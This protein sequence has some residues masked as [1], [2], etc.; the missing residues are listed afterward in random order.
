MGVDRSATVAPTAL[1]EDGARIG[2]GCR[3]GPYCVI[4]PEVTLGEGVTL[5]SHVAV[6]GI[7]SIGAGTEIYPFASIG[8]APQDLKYAG[9]RT[10]L[11][12]VCSSARPVAIDVVR[13]VAACQARGCCAELC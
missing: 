4:G 10:E 7:T 12:A 9:E 2:P 8:H 11:R 3:I 6:A 13:V 1:I 5:P